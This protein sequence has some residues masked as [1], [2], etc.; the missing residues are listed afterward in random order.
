M[1]EKTINKIIT[2][3]FIL[4]CRSIDDEKVRK[5]VEDNTIITGG[6]ITSMLLD[7]EVNDFDCYFRNKE[8]ALAVAEY[9][10][11]KLK[12][13]PPVAFKELA[14]DIKAVDDD[15]RIKIV[16]GKSEKDLR[17]EFQVDAYE[18]FQSQ[19][20][21]TTEPVDPVARMEELDDQAAPNPDSSLTNKGKY[22]VQFITA[23]AITLS[24]RVQIVLRFYGE[25]DEIHTNY[26]YQHCTNAWSS[27]DK[28]LDLRLEAIKCILAKELKYQGSKYPL[29]SILRLRKF[30][31][32]GWTINAGQVLKM[33]WQVSKLDLSDP[34]V[35]EDQ[36]VGVDSAYFAQIITALKE[37]NKEKVDGAYLMSLI[38]KIF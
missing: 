4:W 29:A 11:K 26:D 34:L 28:K 15:G 38:D 36:L 19:I 1:K 23:N 32:R 20:T 14:D 10:V 9:Y 16:F 2:G 3:K 12:I 27:W 31:T 22:H 18:H 13:D 6:C 24:D 21:D 35:L 25:V 33:L 8:T 17:G 37:Q 30:I 7:E 5:L